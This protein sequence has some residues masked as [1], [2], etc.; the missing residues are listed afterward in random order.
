MPPFS[1]A[2]DHARG[3]RPI[4]IGAFDLPLELWL[5]YMTKIPPVDPYLVAAAALG[6]QA[7]GGVGNIMIHYTRPQNPNALGEELQVVAKAATDIG[8]RA[9]VAV[10]MRDQN[11]LGYGPTEQLLDGLQPGDK[12]TIRAKLLSAPQSPQD[13][14]QFV[15]DLAAKIESDLVTVQYGPYGAEWCSQPLLEL[16]AEKS[17]L[18]ARR[19]H[20]HLLEFACSARI[21]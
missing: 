18:N 5:V 11:P 4:S 7:L 3:V 15:D 19:V 9:S 17:A 21:S 14:V 2:H 13:I 1:N 6:R 8:V 20:M 12:D 10:A 16:I